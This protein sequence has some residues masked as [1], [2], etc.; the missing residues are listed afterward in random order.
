MA[1]VPLLAGSN[2]QEGMNLG[3]Q[4]GITNFSSVTEPIL[5]QFLLQITGSAAVVD[6]IK[7][8]LDEI[9]AAFPWYN[10]FEVGAQMY[11]EVV[12]QCVRP[13]AAGLISPQEYT[14]LS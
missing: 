13:H 6:A 5:D 3:P 11:T 9:Q 1:K 4:Y 14:T 7:P 2:G 10:L 12:Y 8:L